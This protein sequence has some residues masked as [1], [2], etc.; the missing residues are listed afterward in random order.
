[1]TCLATARRPSAVVG[2]I[3]YN[4]LD[5]NQYYPLSAQAP[6]AYNVSVSTLSFAQLAAA[7]TGTVPAISTQ[8][9]VAP[10]TAQGFPAQVPWDTVQSASAGVQH[11][12]GSNKVIDR[13]YTLQY[14]HHQHIA[15]SSGTD[16]NDINYIPVGAG[17][18]FNP[19]ALD[20]TTTGSTSNNLNTNLERTLYP[21]Y[22]GIFMATYA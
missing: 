3:F 9:G 4:R 2:G 8:Q 19:A 18:P 6:Q 1:M 15:T 14:V 17:W 10:A 13:G 12:S 20:P 21:G 22:A 7:N 5:G 11:T 16:C